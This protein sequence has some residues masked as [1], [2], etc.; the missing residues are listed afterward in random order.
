VD[1]GIVGKHVFKR[2][3][4]AGALP[5]SLKAAH[6]KKPERSIAMRRIS[7]THA[8]KLPAQVARETNAGLG[9][10]LI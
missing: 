3:G 2:Q 9:L 6:R 8:I 1:D 4:S 7:G 10:R 5:V